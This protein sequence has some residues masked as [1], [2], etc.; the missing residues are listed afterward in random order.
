ME[1]HNEGADY[2]PENPGR[3]EEVAL[4]FPTNLPH[5]SAALMTTSQLTLKVGE[6][7]KNILTVLESFERTFGRK[8]GN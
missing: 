8:H 6:Y 2:H 7:S 5:S 1:Q 4:S 3:E